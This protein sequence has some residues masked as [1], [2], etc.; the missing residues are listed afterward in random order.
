M[1][2]DDYSD[3]DTAFTLVTTER[4]YDFVSTD[5]EE[6]ELWVRVF[7]IVAD[8]NK[9]NRSLANTNPFDFESEQ[10]KGM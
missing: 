1:C 8:M 4:S 6:A 10:L 5:R 2:Y 3:P 9:M 7:S